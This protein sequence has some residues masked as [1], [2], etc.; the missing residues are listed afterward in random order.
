METILH[1]K[2]SPAGVLWTSFVQVFC[3]ACGAEMHYKCHSSPRDLCIDGVCLKVIYCYYHCLSPECKNRPARVARHP[4]VIH[5][6]SYSRSTFTQVVYLKHRRKFSVKQILEELPFLKK[7]TIYN[8]LK[9]YRAA[10]RAQADELI[11]KKFPPGTKIGA[12]FDGM[13]PEKGH[14]C[15][16]TIREVVS[17]VLLGAKFLMDASAEA[18]HEF[19]ESTLNKYGL[20]LTGLISDRQKS[21]V[22]MRDTYYP[23][24]PHQYCIVHFLKNATKGLSDAD[25]SLQK[26]LRSEVRKLSVFKT[27]K[28]KNT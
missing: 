21:I 23:R 27:I 2:P 16:Y 9:V 22:A 7:G 11:A 8:I 4:E 15:L 24:V 13:E 26:D 14:P 3:A 25:K 10:S 19:M 28:K 18:L 5:Q 6:K 1:I 12:S 20:I 17:G